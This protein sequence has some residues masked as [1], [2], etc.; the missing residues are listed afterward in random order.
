M[1]EDRYIV[2]C[3]YIFLLIIG[4]SIT[5]TIYRYIPSFKTNVR[6][7][8]HSWQIPKG[9]KQK[10]SDVFLLIML[11]QKTNIKC[12]SPRHFFGFF[13][14]NFGFFDPK[15]TEIPI[16]LSAPSVTRLRHLH[17]KGHDRHV[18]PKPTWNGGPS[19]GVHVWYRTPPGIRRE[20]SHQVGYV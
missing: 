5:S 16:P 19:V 4:T 18:S 7:K 12:F 8:E 13:R 20:I 17:L 10:H 9:N 3:T 14:L 15:E 1:Y 11:Y 6:L 2:D